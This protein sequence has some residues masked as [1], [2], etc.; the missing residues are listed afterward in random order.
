MTEPSNPHDA[1]FR[2]LVEE[3]EMPAISFA[4]TCLRKS[5]L[6]FPKTLPC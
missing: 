4:I 5:Q 1:L 6:G 2:C 3:P